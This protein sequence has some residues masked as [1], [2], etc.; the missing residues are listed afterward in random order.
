MSLGMDVEYQE[1]RASSKKLAIITGWMGAKPKQLKNYNTWYHDKG[2]DTLQFSVGPQHVLKPETSLALMEVIVKE[3]LALEP[4]IITFHNF[5]V[6]GYLFGQM[7]RVLNE[8]Q[9]A[10]LKRRFV[11]LIKAQVFDSPPD[12]EGIAAGVGASMG[13]NPFIAKPVEFLISGYLKAVENTAGVEHRASSDHFH[14]NHIGAPSMWFYSKADPVCNYKDCLTVI[15]KWR[16]SG[17][18][19]EE[20]VWEDT[21]HIQHGRKDPERY[22]GSL[23]T[24]L[25]KHGLLESNY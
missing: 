4:R 20:V 13:A 16:A 18:E 22:F 7:L 12:M 6:G 11:P 19:V 5:S 14:G 2:F 24:F 1:N 8:P 3:S 25:G 23:D 9:H 17:T 21:P 15:G 10:D